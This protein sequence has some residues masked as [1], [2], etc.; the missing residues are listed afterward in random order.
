[1]TEVLLND[2]SFDLEVRYWLRTNVSNLSVKQNYIGK[3]TSRT[4]IDRLLYIAKK[5]VGTRRELDALKLAADILKQV[6][7]Y[8][9]NFSVSVE[10]CREWM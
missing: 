9:Q 4:Q 6:G 8:R 3:Y 2:L 1:M 10:L 7:F 5:F